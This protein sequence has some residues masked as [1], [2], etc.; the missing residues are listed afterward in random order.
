M[1]IS[2]SGLGSGLDIRGLVS[3]LVSAER[4]PTANRLDL[5]EARANS[6]L[7]ALGRLRGALASFRDSM[8]KLA[9]KDALT[10]RKVSVSNSELLTA[11]ASSSA[12]P[13]S[14]QVEVLQLASRQ[15]LAS[16]TW[17]TADSLVGYGQLTLGIGEQTMKLVIPQGTGSLA[18]I[19]DAINAAT[20]NPGIEASIV[21][22]DGGSRLIISAREA[23]PRELS[24]EASGGDGGL[25]ALDFT[26][27]G[28]DNG[29]SEIQAAAAAVIRIDGFEVTASEGNSF[30]GA[31]DG[32]T[33][34]VSQAEPGT[35][36]DVSIALDL[37]GS[38]QK[39]RGF[40]E[41][42]NRLTGTFA[43]LTRFDPESREAGRLLGDSGLRNLRQALRQELGAAGLDGLSLAAIGISTEVSGRLQLDEQRLEQA[44]SQDLGLVAGLFSGEQGLA[45]RLASLTGGAIASDG[46]IGIREQTLQDQ[47]RRI[48]E[49]REALDRR[50]DQVRARLEAQFNAM[51]QLLGQ[52]RNTS[53]FL[54]QQLP[55]GTL[56]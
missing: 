43:D 49:Q 11:T 45:A 21:N 15:R 10:A 24:I 12:A 36:V 14:Y 39:I 31:L 17:E 46:R 1:S 27:G 22:S 35:R 50:M 44:L 54:A 47:L 2:T 30:T 40:V 19:R 56:Q 5:R 4:Q 53:E 41:S 51:D 26:P 7:S 3:Q 6:E 18:G 33:L 16:G 37:G 9:D 34:N 20:D 32:V 29:L 38:R 23:G 48:G 42:Y 8:E 55:R 13:G 25:A 52:L 28:P